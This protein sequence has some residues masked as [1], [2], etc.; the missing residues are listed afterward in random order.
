MTD[1]HPP[2]LHV[3]IVGGGIGGLV[4]ALALLKSGF[5]V[6]LFE[7]APQIRGLGACSAP[8]KPGSCSISARVPVLTMAH[9]IGWFTV[10]ICRAFS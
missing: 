3:A 8:A 1:T 6:D 2:K 7:Q 9:H 10:A 5:E 4:A